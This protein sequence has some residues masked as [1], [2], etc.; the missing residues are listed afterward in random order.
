MTTWFSETL[1]A[2]A[3]QQLRVGRRI[4]S[5]RTAFHAVEIFENPRHGRVLCLDGIVQTTEA[6]EFDYHEMLVHPAL[7]AHG[8]ARDVLMLAVPT[9]ARCARCCGIPWSGRPWSISTP[10]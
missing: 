3:R 10:R 2:D 6:D 1:Y 4:Y 9:G 5:G 7:F 8:A